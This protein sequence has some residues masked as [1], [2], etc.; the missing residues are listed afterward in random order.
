[1]HLVRTG[2]DE[3]Q[4]IAFVDL[5]TF[6]EIDGEE[7]AIDAALDA[8]RVESGDRTEAGEVDR[9]VLLNHGGDCN[10]HGAW[11]SGR[12]RLLVF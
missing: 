6:P 5:L 9:H 12:E 2:I 3:N 1:L 11:G 7:L 10:G 4:K 8:D